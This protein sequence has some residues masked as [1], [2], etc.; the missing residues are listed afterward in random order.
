VRGGLQWGGALYV[1]G[2]LPLAFWSQ[3]TVGEALY[4]LI[5][6]IVAVSVQFTLSSTGEL[7]LGQVGVFAA[8]SY[9][10]GVLTA[11]HGWN[12]WWSLIPAVAGGCLVGLIAA[13]PSL[14]V[15]SWSFA[16]TNLFIAI[17]V[18]DIISQ[19]T[20]ITGGINGL[21]GIPRPTVAGQALS[22]NDLYWLTLTVLV[23]FLVVTRLLYIS[24]WGLAF[25]AFQRSTVLADSIAIPRLRVKVI[26]YAFASGMAALAGAIFS[27]VD[28]YLS[29]SAFPLSLSILIV[30]AIVIGGLENFLGPIVGVALLQVIPDV[31]T[32]VNRY[33]LLIYGVL[34]IV[35]MLI[36]PEG[37]VPALLDGSRWVWKK[38]PGQVRARLS[39]ASR[40]TALDA[41]AVPAHS[42]TART[43]ASTAVLEAP[44]RIGP[45]RVSQVSKAFDGVPALESVD[46]TAGTG[47]IAAIIGPNG[48]GKTTLLNVICG[49][50]RAD[51]GS[52][53]IG[54]PPVG[55]RRGSVGRT[56]QTPMVIE[57]RSVME[58]VM[59]GAFV[60]R[61]ATFV[62]SAL[63]LGRARG[64]RRRARALAE[65]LL[66]LVELRD[67]A[68]RRAD[69]LTLA[70]QRRLEI[71][72]ALAMRPS[73]LLL[74]EPCAGLSGTDVE[75]LADIMDRI[76]E[77]QYTVVLVE[78]NVDLVMLLA[79][80]I[81]VLDAGTAIATGTPAEVRENPDVIDSYLGVD[82]DAED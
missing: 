46:F 74:D 32:V 3:S 72:R 45:I 73:A 10:S 9:I 23:G 80:E 43:A 82:F 36:I 30:A 42:E 35:V 28:G 68:D 59:T 31:T 5:L 41:G 75:Q 60:S 2:L 37:L 77:A 39:A 71:A 62:E 13:S 27:T 61:Q 12:F 18:V 29:P 17:V 38:L 1:I 19:L 66:S 67:L 4:I 51:G 22:Q 44:N 16:L 79:D 64:D 26:T 14:R 47:R 63:H 15:G 54:D 7:A 53:A 70:Q 34:L 55:S 48:S 76:R 65:D 25:S 69:G 56:F 58:N 24:S 8:G 33:S 49:F 40:R 11:L 81:T 50:L 52:V 78:H 57:R 6:S 21:A 20:S